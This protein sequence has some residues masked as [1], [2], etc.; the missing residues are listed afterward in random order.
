MANAYL[1][2]FSGLSKG[3]GENGGQASCI[4]L[5]PKA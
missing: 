3:R 4:V 1:D 5:I 2:F